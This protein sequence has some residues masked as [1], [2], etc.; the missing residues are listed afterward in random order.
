MAALH[1]EL[2][3][4]PSAKGF[5]WLGR[6]V[7]FWEAD[8]V[9]ALEWAQWKAARGD[10]SEPFVVGAVIDL[11]NCLDL[12]VRKN[13]GLLED[14]Y[15]GLKAEIQAA[16]GPFPKNRDVADDPFEDKLLRY[17]DYAVIEKVHATLDDA[18]AL[19]A[20][21]VEPFDTVRGLFQEGGPAY[22]DGGIFAKT[23]TQIAVR[24][25]RAIKGVFLPPPEH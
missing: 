1:R 11:G 5:D 21:T 7:Y 20:P 6:G 22:P 2:E 10:Y 25:P 12:V 3:L 17:L 14:A 4:Q 13:I 16:G 8:P 24:N 15:E 19:G 18:A 9:R 23:H